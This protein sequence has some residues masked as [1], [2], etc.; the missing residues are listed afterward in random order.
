[1]VR[2]RPA[3]SVPCFF[4]KKPAGISL[5]SFCCA[6]RVTP[7]ASGQTEP[8]HHFGILCH[9]GETLATSWGLMTQSPAGKVVR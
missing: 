3:G 7:Q 6:W 2:W 5:Q 8:I 1:M 4:R 9:S